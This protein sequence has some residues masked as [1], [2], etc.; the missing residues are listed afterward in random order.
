MAI[1]AVVSAAIVAS[2]PTVSAMNR[3]AVDTLDVTVVAKSYF[4]SVAKAWETRTAFDAAVLP[5]APSTATRTCTASMANPDGAIAPA[6]RLRVEL[7][8]VAPG[9]NPP[10]V[11]W[12]DVGRPAA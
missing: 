6:I 1:L 12:L 3:G 7:R 2:M 9:S 4:E 11:F 10:R 5:A 8:C